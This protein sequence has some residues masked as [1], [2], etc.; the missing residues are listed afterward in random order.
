M[1]GLV[2]WLGTLQHGGGKALHLCSFEGHPNIDPDGARGAQRSDSLAFG[3]EQTGTD[4]APKFFVT[5]NGRRTGDPKGGILVQD[6]P[7]EMKAR[8]EAIERDW[9]ATV[10]PAP[11][12]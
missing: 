8:I 3:A 10:R 7:N 5:P 12:T 4:I 2:D 11:P 6:L 1:N 9:V